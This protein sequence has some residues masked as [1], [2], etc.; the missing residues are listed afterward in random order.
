MSDSPTRKRQRYTD[1]QQ[2]EA[3]ALVQAN[4]GDTAATSAAT[5]IPEATLRAWRDGERRPPVVQLCSEKKEALAEQFEALAERAVQVA[6]A[7]VESASA[8]DAAVIAGIATDKALLLRGEATAIV[9][10][11]DDARLAELRARYVEAQRVAREELGFELPAL[12]P[13]P[14]EPA[15]LAPALPPAPPATGSGRR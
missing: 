5:G 12:P 14:G 2:A 10:H 4:G 8:R 9:Q 3:L 15:V 1:Q 13:A 6:D 7:K 11:Q